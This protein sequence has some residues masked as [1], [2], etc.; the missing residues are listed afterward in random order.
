MKEQI[1]FISV[2]DTNTNTYYSALYPV[3]IGADIKEAYAEIK[4]HIEETYGI[5][6][7]H[8]FAFNPV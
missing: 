6:G 7:I 8:V 4:A 5:H 3:H 1:Y 2:M